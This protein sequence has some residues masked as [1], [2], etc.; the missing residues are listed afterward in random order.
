GVYGV[1]KALGGQ[2]VCVVTA[3]QNFQKRTG[4]LVAQANAATAETRRLQGLA[5][6]LGGIAD[7]QHGMTGTPM[8]LTEKTKKPKKISDNIN[9]TEDV[10]AEAQKYAEM[11]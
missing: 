5:A 11:I 8:Q 10:I 6:Q 4:E 2:G 1:P 9:R 7:R 3:A